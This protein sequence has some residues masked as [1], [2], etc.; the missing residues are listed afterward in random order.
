MTSARRRGGER[1]SAGDGVGKD[2]FRG[3][4]VAG[5]VERASTYRLS[6]QDAREIVDHQIEVIESQ[7]SESAI[8]PRSAPWTTSGFWR[9][10]FLN[11]Y[12]TEGYPQ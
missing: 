3:S 9:R 4:Q 10:Q 1:G 7:W 5:C 11:P 2:G 12:A 6:E 8:R